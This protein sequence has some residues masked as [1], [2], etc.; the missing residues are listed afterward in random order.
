MQG[1]GNDFVVLDDVFLVLVVLDD[2]F[3]VLVLLDDEERT[4]DVGVVAA[5]AAVVDWKIAVLSDGPVEPF[6]V[7]YHHR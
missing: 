3:L 2:A 6:A 1:A 4:V 5:A 7:Y